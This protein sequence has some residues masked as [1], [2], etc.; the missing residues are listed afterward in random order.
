LCK[1]SIC[2]L[3]TILFACAKKFKCKLTNVCANGTCANL[4]MYEL[5]HPELYMRGPVHV[6]TYTYA[7]C[8]CAN[9]HM[10]ELMHVKLYMRG[11]IHV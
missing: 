3:S 1:N 10:Y 7:T 4:H 9:L 6:Q 11:P 8:T 5:M 2:Q